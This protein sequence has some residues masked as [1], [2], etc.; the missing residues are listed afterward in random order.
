MSSA[1]KPSTNNESVSEPI[2]HQVSERKKLHFTPTVHIVYARGN[3]DWKES[4]PQ[5]WMGSGYR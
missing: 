4:F 1:V 2:L 5:V 3:Q